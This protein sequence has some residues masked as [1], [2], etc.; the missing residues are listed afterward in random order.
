MKMIWD[1]ISKIEPNISKDSIH[2]EI[3][4]LKYLSIIKS[5]KVSI[6]LISISTNEVSISASPIEA[7]QS[8][9]IFVWI[10]F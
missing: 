3:K 1:A 6:S 10:Y 9:E 7:W 2:D 5:Y 8:S 4:I